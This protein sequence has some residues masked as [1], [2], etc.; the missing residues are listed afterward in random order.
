M[1]ARVSR[2]SSLGNGVRVLTR[3][4]VGCSSVGRFSYIGAMSEI[5]LSD[6][7]AFCSVGPRVLVGLGGHP[8]SYATTYPGFY[9]SSASG[10]KFF[11]H[12]ATYEGNEKTVI[13]A[14][15]WLGARSSVLG[16]V[17][18]GCGAVIAAGAVVTKDVLPYQI[19]GGVPAKPI[20]RRFDDN[21][22]DALMDSKWWTL[23]ESVLRELAKLVDSPLEFGLAAI[24]ALDTGSS[25]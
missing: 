14:D 25:K 5:A 19:V 9:S 6:V 3:A 11:G 7:G 23:D 12:E 17:R 16:G 1:S 8:T 20:R 21:V 2:D 15:V 24:R 22:C 10:A 13:G 18:V 4:K